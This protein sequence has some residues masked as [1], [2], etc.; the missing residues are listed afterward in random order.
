ME[1]LGLLLAVGIIVILAVT[2]FRRAIS[3]PSQKPPRP[4]AP[5]PSKPP[6][7][8]TPTSKRVTP[9]PAVF[10]VETS[11]PVQRPRLLTGRAYVIDGDSL[12]IQKT[13]VRLF[14]IDAPE[15][16]HP[17]GKRAKWAMFELCKNQIVTAE[18]TDIDDHG[19]TVAK[20]ML[21][22]GRDLSAE[23]VKQG[24]ALDWPKY[25]GGIYRHFETT[26]ARKKLWLADARQKGRMHVWEKFDAQQRAKTSG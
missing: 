5:T 1:A 19:R 12:K 2:V 17:F 20:C 14:G 25:S 7:L 26:D 4:A 8:P 23:L 18:I 16:N 21:S 15:M 24:L 9:R 22:D 3:T 10:S 6:S 13:Q 11:T